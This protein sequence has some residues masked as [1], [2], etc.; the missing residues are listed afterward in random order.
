MGADLSVV[1][2]LETTGLAAGPWPELDGVDSTQA[3]QRW[4]EDLGLYRSMLERW[5]REFADI[6]TTAATGRP[7]P[8]NPLAARLHKLR[9]GASMLGV[10]IIP[11]LAAE[12]E[13]A[14]SAGDPARTAQLLSEIA[15]QMQRLRLSAAA[16]FGAALER[17]PQPQDAGAPPI[18]AP[19]IDAL[20]VAL[21]QQRP[22]AREQFIAI[23]PQLQRLLDATAL[24]RLGDLIDALQ[25]G[26][27]AD[28]LEQLQFDAAA[29]QAD[30]A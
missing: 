7:A 14:C 28:A 27:A 22:A 6:A 1:D 12:A 16:T 15:V 2:E 8:A 29:R 5:L 19:T 21:R 26:A 24:T 18:G 3:R 30:A 13:A 20:L 11:A 4:C 10:A 25:F 9:G 17:V 23:S